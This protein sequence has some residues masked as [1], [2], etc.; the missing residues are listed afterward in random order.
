MMHR[1][2]REL[3]S[4]QV[5]IIDPGKR[6][7]ASVALVLMETPGGPDVLLIERSIDENDLWSGHIGFP[8]GR[9]EKRDKS[10]RHTAER[11]VMEELG[12]DLSA[13]RYL[14]RLG[15][16]A[17]GGLPMVVS[18][19]VYALRRSPALHPD[20][21]EV[22][23]AFWFPVR[24]ISNPARCSYVEILFH[25]RL[26]R[27]PALMLDDAGGPLL[28]GISYRLLRNLCKSARSTT[29]P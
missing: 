16:I 1:I 29:G 17:P 2:S 20:H 21:L 9:A 23:R 25:K 3:N 6:A 22:A 28:W 10:P 26:L 5:R 11:E 15:D 19:F 7:H 4:R 14:G 12:L 18:A 13:E 27:F 8:G 24:E